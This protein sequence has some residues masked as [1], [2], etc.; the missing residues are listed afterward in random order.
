MKLKGHFKIYFEAVMFEVTSFAIPSEGTPEYE[1]L[2]E[3]MGNSLFNENK[4]SHIAIKQSDKALFIE[5]K[6][7]RPLSEIMNNIEALENIS[8][9]AASFT[10]KKQ[11]I[12][13]ISYLRYHIENY[14]NELYILKNRLIAYLTLIERSY[15]KCGRKEHISNELKPIYEIV[16]NS[17]GKYINVRGAHVHQQRYTDSEIDK[18][19]ELELLSTHSEGKY[20]N[21]M[22]HLYMEN[23]KKI[24]QKWVGK[25]KNDI[26]EVEKLTE[27][28]FEKICNSIISNEKIIYPKNTK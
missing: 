9:Y 2:K 27:I 1:Q 24:R 16:S 3:N 28:F 18:L 5:S 25:M 8:I 4:S 6:L 11:G 23:Y 7:F 20:S 13:R 19:V 26:I 10:Y 17:L 21:L 15:K 12:S 14:L 22:T